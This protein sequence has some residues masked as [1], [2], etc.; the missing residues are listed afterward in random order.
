MVN[1][2]V[3][4]LLEDMDMFYLEEQYHILIKN[5]SY[6]YKELYEDKAVGDI[7][8]KNNIVVND[9]D[10]DE[11]SKVLKKNKKEPIEINQPVEKIKETILVK[12]RI[13][14]KYLS[15][16]GKSN[17]LYESKNKHAVIFYHK[18]LK[19]IY[20]D[21]WIKKCVDSVLNQTF[22]EF[23]ILEVNYGNE[24]VSLVDYYNYDMGDRKYYFFKQNFITH[25]EAMLFL[26][27]KCFMEMDYDVVYNTNLDDYYSL[28]RFKVQNKCVE[29]G[30]MLCSSLMNYIREDKEGVD[31][32][33]M[34]WKAET[35]SMYCDDNDE[36]IN[37]NEIKNQLKKDHNVINHSCVCYTRNFWY[38]HDKY[39]NLLRYRDDKPFEDLSLWQRATNIHDNITIINQ[40]L[41]EYRLHDNSI[42]EQQKKFIEKVDLDEG[43]DRGFNNKKST[44]K[45]RIGIFLIGTGKYI[46]YLEELVKDIEKNFITGYP[47]IYFISSDNE[48]YVNEIKNKYKININFKKFLK[49]VF[50]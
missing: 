47:H 44:D 28:D 12:D 35:Y 7:L 27:N 24:N 13:I 25:T 21:R 8:F 42:G 18:N 19:K 43:T 26:L 11:L 41:I 49:K 33:E 29:D 37:I 45:K 16:N 2:Y 15:N 50:H 36:Y 23:D 4:M 31:K 9:E 46:Y 17:K 34:K 5:K 38:S 20:K 6:F 39:D 48:D 10:Y 22:Q 14:Y 30:Y 32:E 1:F 3:N 40:P